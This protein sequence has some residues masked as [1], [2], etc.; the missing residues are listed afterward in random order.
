VIGFV[1]RL[2]ELSPEQYQAYLASAAGEPCA[3]PLDSPS[4]LR[5]AGDRAERERGARALRQH[6]CT[7]CHVIPGLT[8]SDSQVGPPLRG[9]ASR[10]LI[11]GRLPNT[12]ENLVRWIRAPQAVKPGTAM[13]DL[14]VTEA[15]AREMATYLS[16]LY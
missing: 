1:A 11:A 5:V 14:G 3:G 9:L 12:Q 2:P 6:A 8:G 15:Q 7:S 13:P 4:A 10:S 16:S